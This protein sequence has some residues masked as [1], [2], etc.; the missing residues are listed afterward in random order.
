MKLVF[1]AV[2]LCLA[3]ALSVSAG[4]KP[5]FAAQEAGPPALDPFAAAASRTKLTLYRPVPAPEGFTLGDVQLVTTPEDV[6]MISYYHSDGREVFIMESSPEGLDCPDC[7]TI[8][9]NGSPAPY[10]ETKGEDGSAM[11]DV[12]VVRDGT[13]LVVGIRGKA[14]MSTNDALLT[15]RKIAEAMQKVEAPRLPSASN[16]ETKGRRDGLRE[17]AAQAGF[18]I[19][20]PETLPQYFYLK[21]VAYTP[22]GLASDGKLSTPEQLLIT[23]AAGKK[24]IHLLLQ[25]PGA[26]DMS[27]IAGKRSKIGQWAAVIG[28]GSGQPVITLDL[29]DCLAVLSGDVQMTTLQSVARSLSPGQL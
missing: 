21:T 12:T 13:A 7:R 1:K 28:Q 25:A 27:Q 11:V 23:Y 3:A 20:S 2:I 8:E 22:K 18:P 6:L 14:G 29:G 26:F 15:L 16:P 17:A 4:P 19:Y 24:E 9:I 5:A 10:E